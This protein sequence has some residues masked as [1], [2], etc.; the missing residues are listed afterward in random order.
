MPKPGKGQSSGMARLADIKIT[1]KGGK[2][3]GKVDEGKK[4]GKHGK[5]KS[6]K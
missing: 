5:G 2:K 1:M 6:C 4:T 3:F